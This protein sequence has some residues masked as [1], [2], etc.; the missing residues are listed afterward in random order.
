MSPVGGKICRDR[1]LLP[2]LSGRTERGK[3][4]FYWVFRCGTALAE[5][6]GVNDWPPCAALVE[7]C[8]VACPWRRVGGDRCPPGADFLEVIVRE[9]RRGPPAGRVRFLLRFHGLGR[10]KRR[11]KRRFANFAGDDERAAGRAE[12]VF[13]GASAPTSRSDALKHLFSQIDGD[14]DGKITKSEFEKAL[15][16]GG[17]NVAKADDVFSKLD[18]N[19]DGSVSLDEMSQALN[20]GKGRHH[21]HHHTAGGLGRQWLEFGSAD[22]GAA[23]RHQHLRHQQRRFDDDVADLC[24]RIEGHDDVG[25]HRAVRRAPRPRPTISSSR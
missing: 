24:G 17:T 19:G 21:H 8:H 4:R 15:G 5:P 23:G 22:A 11:R 2:V 1:H 7:F 16:A 25:R 10:P 18:K 13:D 14:G 20:G 3:A 12:P 9:I 6:I